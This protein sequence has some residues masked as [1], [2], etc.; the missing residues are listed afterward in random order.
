MSTVKRTL[1]LLVIIALAAGTNVPAQDTHD[2]AVAALQEIERQGFVGSVLVARDGNIEYAG[3]FGFS[4]EQTSTP[5]YWIASITKQFV[6]TGILLLHERGELDINKPASAYLAGVSDDKAGITLFQLLTHTS[7]MAQ[8]YAA[9]GIADRSEALQALLAPELQSEPGKAF[10]YAN[11]NYNI[12]AIVLEIV[13]GQSYETFMYE[14]VFVPAGMRETA[15]WGSPISS[16]SSV[17]PVAT[18][19]APAAM[20]QNWGFRGATGMRASV[21]DLFSFLQ[22]LEAGDLLSEQSL[23]L[24]QGNHIQTAG[25]TEIGFNWFGRR[26]DNGI[27]ARFSRGQESFGGNAVI[28]VYPERGLTIITAT[29]AG[30]AETGDGSVT[31]WSRITH[32]A[33]AEI[34]LAD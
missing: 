21:P 7:G 24:L 14:Q 20:Q 8:N 30:P 10:S 28:Y 16:T 29:N 22:S 18:P 12:L 15:S 5:S 1:P 4:E 33:L 17:P 26:L 34:F 6:A 3:D 32:E 11:D 2:A 27:Y 9:D 31:G 13:S 25:G 19:M 23:D